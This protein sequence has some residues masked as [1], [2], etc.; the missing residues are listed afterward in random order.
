V[1]ES[2]FKNK[3]R[4]HL[5]GIIP[6]QL[7]PSRS[8]L[9]TNLSP[10]CLS[11]LS[12]L[13]NTGKEQILFHCLA[14]PQK[15]LTLLSATFSLPLL[16]PSSSTLSMLSSPARLASVAVSNTPSPMLPTSSLRRTPRPT[17]STA[18]SYAVAIYWLY[19]LLTLSTI[20]STLARQLHREPDLIPWCSSHLWP[21]LPRSFCCP[22]RWL[23]S[24]SCILRHWILLWRSPGT[25][26]V[27]KSLPI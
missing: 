14:H 13:P 23:G 15:Q 21:P 2:L 26:G 17:S 4:R 22:R 16:P 5:Y 6:I 8:S 24:L 20:S 7:I 9:L 12:S 10:S 19:L 11:S 25:H 18:V 1:E 27:C 3:G